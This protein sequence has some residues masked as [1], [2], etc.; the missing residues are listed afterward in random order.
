MEEPAGTYY[1]NLSKNEGNAVS[2]T[3]TYYNENFE[4]LGS[5]TFVQG[6]TSASD[7]AAPLY[8][9]KDGFTV[10]RTD[11]SSNGGVSLFLKGDGTVAV[12]YTF[13]GVQ[14]NYSAS[15]VENSSAQYGDEGYTVGLTDF[16]QSGST[17]SELKGS[18]V[19][20]DFDGK[21]YSRIDLTVGEFSYM[22]VNVQD[23]SAWTISHYDELSSISVRMPQYSTGLMD[24]WR[25]KKLSETEKNASVEIFAN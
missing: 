1:S 16:K 18:A 25:Y 11:A 4:V 9:Q 8:E 20:R 17:I 7:E 6:E 24:G 22:I 5:R 2:Y 12:S 3:V 14:Y 23:V 10:V 15:V 13:T 21:Q 19:F